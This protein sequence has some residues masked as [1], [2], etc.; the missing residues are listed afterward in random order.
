[1][2][3]ITQKQL[4]SSIAIFI[5]KKIEPKS[6]QT[7]IRSKKCSILSG[8]PP[9]L[10]YYSADSI[11]SQNQLYSCYLQSN[12]KST[13]QACMEIGSGV[14]VTNIAQLEKVEIL[15]FTCPDNAIESK[16]KQINASTPLKG[17]LIINCSDEHFQKRHC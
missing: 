13:K 15:W 8:Y 7:L 16:V 11:I 10:H 6:I 9:E 2:F 12:L 5:Y 1:M 4:G 14:P 17:R 3:H